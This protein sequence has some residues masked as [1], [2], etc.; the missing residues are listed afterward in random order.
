MTFAS[1]AL[2]LRRSR[3]PD[4]LSQSLSPFL[5]SSEEAVGSRCGGRRVTRLLVQSQGWRVRDG[6]HTRHRHSDPTGNKGDEAV[7]DWERKEGKQERKELLLV[8]CHGQST[9]A[10][11]QSRENGCKK[12]LRRLLHLS[13]KQASR[14]AMTRESKRRQ[15]RANDKTVNP[16]H[17]RRNTTEGQSYR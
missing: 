1:P 4:H 16:S 15:S 8:Q 3:T 12:Q 9:K 11:M 6:M 10:R 2:F 14:A 17:E 5:R 7:I 13:R